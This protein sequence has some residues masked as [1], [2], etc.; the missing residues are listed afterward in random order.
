MSFVSSSA[1][2]V[3]HSSS[4]SSSIPLSHSS[5]PSASPGTM[6]DVSNSSRAARPSAY[7]KK[8]PSPYGVSKSSRR[9]SPLYPPHSLIRKTPRAAKAEQIA[10]RQRYLQI[11]ALRR[12]GIYL[13]EEYHDE[14][15]GYMHE[16]EVSPSTRTPCKHLLNPGYSAAPCAIWCRWTNNQRSDGICVPAWWT[17]SWSFTSSSGFARKRS[18]SR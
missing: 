5:P 3:A 16:M 18:T 12:E 7:P 6:K 1:G 4:S 11:S 10:Q 17:S 15:R 8:K 9:Q 14:I 13:E 2:A